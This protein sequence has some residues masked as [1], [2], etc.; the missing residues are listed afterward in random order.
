MRNTYTHGFYI[1]NTT[2]KN[3]SKVLPKFIINQDPLL[4]DYR[5][6]RSKASNACVSLSGCVLEHILLITHFSDSEKLFYILANTLSIVNLH[7]GNQ[8]SVALSAE[9]WAK[10]L[11]CAK[12]QV[13]AMQNSLE[14]KGYFIIS[15]DRNKEG[16]NKR[17]LICP[18]LPDEVFKDLSQNAANRV[19][20][21][22]LRYAPHYESKLQ[23]LDRTK[24]FIMLGYQV[25][26]DIASCEYL[27]PFH[28]LV[29]LDCYASCYKAR[30]ANFG[31]TSNIEGLEFSFI[32]SYQQLEARFSCNKSTISTTLSELE[33]LGLIKREHFYTRKELGDQERQDRSLWK[34][35][36]PSSSPSISP[37]TSPSSHSSTS[38]EENLFLMD[39]DRPNAADSNGKSI[40]MGSSSSKSLSFG[41]IDSSSTSKITVRNVI[42]IAKSDIGEKQLEHVS[43]DERCRYTGSHIEQVVYELSEGEGRNREFDRDDVIEYE[44]CEDDT[45][46]EYVFE[47]TE[48]MQDVSNICCNDPDI[49]SS[50]LYIKKDIN[51]N[52][53]KSNLVKGEESNNLLRNEIKENVLTNNITSTVYSPKTSKKMYQ[54]GMCEKVGGISNIDSVF[55]RRNLKKEIIHK[56]SGFNV[57]NLLIKEKLKLFSKDKADKA[58]KFAYSL[59]SKKITKGYASTLS[60][61]ELAKQFIFHATSWKPTKVGCGASDDKL[62]DVALTVAWKSAVTGSWQEPLEW[63]KAKALQYEFTAY[64]KK[65]KESGII[66]HELRSLESMINNLLKANYD[67]A[68]I[69][70]QEVEMNVQ[71]RNN[72]V[73]EI[74]EAPEE[75]GAIAQSIAQGN[76]T[77]EVM[78]VQECSGEIAKMQDLTIAP[79]SKVK[80]VFTKINYDASEVLSAGTS[81]PGE[82]R[83]KS[84]N[85]TNLYLRAVLPETLTNFGGFLGNS[86][87][88]HLYFNLQNNSN[89][90]GQGNNAPSNYQSYVDKLNLLEINNKGEL[91]ITLQPDDQFKGSSD[92]ANSNPSIPRADQFTFELEHGNGMNAIVSQVDL[93]SQSDQHLSKDFI[94]IDQALSG[95]LKNL[96]RGN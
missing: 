50:S 29:W 47:S 6:S 92:F 23:Y 39:K 7:G 81:I 31:V 42:P 69:I 82:D 90:D 32:T 71:E 25:L 24:L 2:I 21:Q 11:N 86:L 76:G 70:A 12:S 9:S 19:G 64:K 84:I 4:F 94:K 60:K 89:K 14:A 3:D 28:K 5:S 87:A 41:N 52:I 61:H 40:S 43:G 17:N 75:G 91:V 51:I 18:T 8:R 37:P 53:F 74:R 38:S 77:A 79:S 22:K 36:L 48:R 15:R 54:N 56:A 83:K 20:E 10:R 45:F 88:Q 80:N 55:R 26:K 67:L 46:D 66:S 1:V 59:F 35:S 78:E 27:S 57:S 30:V 62:I 73:A 49:I 65:F 85:D 68:T 63:A 13:F 96:K 72:E 95:I 16:Q 93:Q 44:S 34:I 33:E 58:R